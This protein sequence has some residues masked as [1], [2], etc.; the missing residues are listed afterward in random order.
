MKN[1]T[2]IILLLVCHLGLSQEIKNQIIK[3]IETKHKQVVY[4]N[5]KIDN[6]FLDKNIT[7]TS[8][9]EGER[10]V[11]ETYSMLRNFMLV[12]SNN[13]KLR[14]E[15]NEYPIDIV[16]SV[17]YTF[18]EDANNHSREYRSYQI[19]K[20]NYI[21]N[22]SLKLSIDATAHVL[23]NGTITVTEGGH[24]GRDW[25]GLYNKDFKELHNFKPFNE[26]SNISF[27]RNENYIVY[28]AQVETDSIIRLA[29]YGGF[30]SYG[31]LGTREIKIN[32]SLILSSVKVVKDNIFVLLSST[33]SGHSQ[34]LILNKDL[35]EINKIKLTERVS[36]NKIVS[37]NE[38]VYLNTRSN[39]QVY[40]ISG[41]KKGAIEKDITKP[42]K[43]D[44]GYKFK[45]SNI[46]NFN[47]E[48]LLLLEASYEDNVTEIKDVS[49]QIFDSQTQK[50]LQKTKVD[51]IFSGDLR[52]EQS[53]GSLIIF[54]NSKSLSY[55]KV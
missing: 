16:N 13:N 1:T 52:L 47:N 38:N 10:Y 49:I 25:I 50:L 55:E 42:I 29:V 8:I 11:K 51:D 36:H 33:K 23:K 48:Y 44:Y 31:Q 21:K 2:I 45:G 46:Y 12:D 39:I 3:Q 40:D 37:I 24:S 17:L 53:K 41:K 20:E 18:V 27:D 35:E 7:Y 9:L 19:E 34:I 6:I 30:A 43:T 22:G 4:D 14:L 32:N 54:S 28:A 26:E 5:Q 15:K